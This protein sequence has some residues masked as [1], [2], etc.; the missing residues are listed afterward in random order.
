MSAPIYT[1][2]D[3]A[4][5]LAGN[6]S[7]VTDDVTHLLIF[8]IATWLRRQAGIAS[9][10]DEDVESELLYGLAEDLCDG[11]WRRAV[12]TCCEEHAAGAEWHSENCVTRANETTSP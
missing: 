4:K 2:D 6:T 10:S 9:A 7:R 1:A 12:S 11:E 3:M 8:Q 5:A